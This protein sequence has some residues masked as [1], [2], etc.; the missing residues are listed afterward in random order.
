M[1]SNRSV[2]NRIIAEIE[3]LAP[4]GDIVRF[5]DEWREHWQRTERWFARFREQTDGQTDGRGSEERQDDVYAFFQ[6]AHH[7]KDWLANSTELT[8]CELDEFVDNSRALCICAD[9]CNG[10]KHLKV[11]T[12]R[13]DPDTRIQ[14]R[15]VTIDAPSVG[16]V[17]RDG[18][19]TPLPGGGGSIQTT[20]EV[21][22]G[23]GTEAAFAL[24]EECMERWERYL[25]SKRLLP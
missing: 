24:A 12:I 1:L 6:S 4:A 8:R 17:M 16:M 10:S 9:L 21:A 23:G 13:H 20:Y 11:T 2:T 7:L 15:S 25:R 18:V 3:T 19:V 5:M 22:T 14:S